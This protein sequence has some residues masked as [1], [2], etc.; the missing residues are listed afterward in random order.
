MVKQCHVYHPVS[1]E[2]FIYTTY[3]YGDFSWGMVQCGHCFTHIGINHGWE[4]HAQNIIYF[5]GIMGHGCPKKHLLKVP[6]M[7]DLVIISGYFFGTHSHR[8]LEIAW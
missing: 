7:M 4:I 6:E 3:K 5:H 8:M 1:W 2:W